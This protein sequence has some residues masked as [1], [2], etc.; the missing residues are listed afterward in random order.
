[1][2][3]R[4]IFIFDRDKSYASGFARYAD[5]HAGGARAWA[6][7]R[8]EPAFGF[9][10]EHT[11]DILIASEPFAELLAGEDAPAVPPGSVY[12]LSEEPVAD[13]EGGPVFYKYQSAGAILSRVLSDHEARQ[14]AGKKSAEGSRIAAVW[15]PLGRCGKTGLARALAETAGRTGTSLFLSL[16]EW[17]GDPLPGTDDRPGLSE[18]LYQAG[19]GSR[20]LSLTELLTEVRCFQTIPPVTCPEDIRRQ[21]PEALA[22][23]IVQITRDGGF[24]TTVIDVS[25]ALTDVLPVLRIADAVIVPVLP[26]AGAQEKLARAEAALRRREAWEVLQRLVR[27]EVPSPEPDDDLLP[28]P[29]IRAAQTLW[30]RIR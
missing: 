11:P 15:S 26:E 28:D 13:G 21:D 23:L 1:M 10:R 25:D 27:T 5:L 30:E 12:R 24:G 9:L 18:L 22:E 17:V 8:K 3:P 19:T 4:E 29:L 6:F 7:T 14:Q 16:E 20:E 2:R